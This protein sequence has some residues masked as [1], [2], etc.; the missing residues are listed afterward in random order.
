MVCWQNRP[1]RCRKGHAARE[2]PVARVHVAGGRLMPDGACRAEGTTRGHGAR[3]EH[4]VQRASRMEGC[5]GKRR[6][7]GKGLPGCLATAPAAV[8]HTDHQ[9]RWA[10]SYAYATQLLPILQPQPCR[11][12]SIGSRLSHHSTSQLAHRTHAPPSAQLAPTGT[13]NV[14]S[15]RVQ[16]C[17]LACHS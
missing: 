11:I 14:A 12:T 10:S 17:T 16:H 5:F 9:G 8:V 13:S 3:L 1:V 6:V 4:R 7:C 2:G 15:P